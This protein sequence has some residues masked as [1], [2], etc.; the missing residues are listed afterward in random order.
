MERNCKRKFSENEENGDS[1]LP[2]V[3]YKKLDPYAGTSSGVASMQSQSPPVQL[4]EES[5]NVSQKS[6]V[7]RYEEFHQYKTKFSPY[8]VQHVNSR[9]PR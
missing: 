2:S 1:Q 4:N 7:P 8:I 6:L 5:K 9:H 3:K